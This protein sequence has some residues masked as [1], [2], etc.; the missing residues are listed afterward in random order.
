MPEF[1][2]IINYLNASNHLVL[3]A[4]LI[5]V[6]GVLEAMT[7]QLV[8]IWFVIGALASLVASLCHASLPIQI[9][10]FVVV[11]IAALLITRPIV[12]KYVNP[13]KER[14]NADKVIGQLGIVTEDI[15][16]IDGVGQVKVDGKIWTARTADGSAVLAGQEVVIDRIE[17]VKLIVKA[18]E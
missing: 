8:S 13:K 14:T 16:N 6:F 12:K 17:G 5:V 11:S 10:V 1:S 15:D 2:Q 7:A 3:W 9:I 4:V 18:K